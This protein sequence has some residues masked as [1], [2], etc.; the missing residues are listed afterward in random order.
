MPPFARKTFSVQMLVKISMKRSTISSMLFAANIAIEQEA[1]VPA[2]TIARSM[3][4][5]F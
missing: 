4:A 1:I 2:I 3:F 5:R